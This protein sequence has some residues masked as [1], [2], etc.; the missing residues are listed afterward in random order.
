L[1]RSS[2]PYVAASSASTV[3]GSGRRPPSGPRTGAD[4]RGPACNPVLGWRNPLNVIDPR[5]RRISTCEIA[6]SPNEMA[7]LR[8]RR[9]NVASPLAD[10]RVGLVGLGRDVLLRLRTPHARPG[11]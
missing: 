10:P 7:R 8:S 5:L 1:T 6:V 2:V 3:G 9:G 4:P 11:D